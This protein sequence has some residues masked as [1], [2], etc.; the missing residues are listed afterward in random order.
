MLALATTLFLTSCS[1]E[2]S[3][4]KSRI[5]YYPVLEIQGG[6]K[7]FVDKGS[8][9]VDPGYTATLDGKDV[10]DQVN[11]TSNLNTNESGIYTI[12]YSIVNSD[13]FAANARR[14]V[15][16]L[17]PNSAVEGIYVT[18]PQSYRDYNGQ[19]AYGRSFEILIFDNGNGTYNVDDLLGGWY[20]QRAGY[21]SNYAM[22]G[23]I[24]IDESGEISLVDSYVPGWNDGATDLTGHFDAETHHISWVCEYTDYPFFFHVELDKE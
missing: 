2:D 13:G 22:Q 4:G 11:V 19:V 12:T 21:G 20:C 17:D 1:D 3:E 5:T 7:I 14:T 16:V 18:D 15:V 6:S 23:V 8:V 9:F 24:A 10:T